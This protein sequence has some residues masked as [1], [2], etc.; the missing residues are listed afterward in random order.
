[1]QDANAPCLHAKRVGLTITACDFMDK[2]KAQLT[3]E[4]DVD[5]A[6]VFGN[7]FRG[8]ARLTNR[9]GDQAQVGMNVVS[10]T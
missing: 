1:M 5:A 7:R 8:S 2:G 10:K 6:L 4:P 9:A 3:S